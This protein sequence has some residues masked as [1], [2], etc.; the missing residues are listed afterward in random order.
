MYYGQFTAPGGPSSKIGKA[1]AATGGVE[2]SSFTVPNAGTLLGMAFA[3]DGSLY[4]T[5]CQSNSLMRCTLNA[6]GDILPMPSR[7]GAPRTA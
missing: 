2:L 3:P 6:S 5:G 4:V 7:S 1:S